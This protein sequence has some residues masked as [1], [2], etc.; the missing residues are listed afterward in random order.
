MISL[1]YI[2]I[3]FV[4]YRIARIVYNL[5]LHPLAKVPGP[6]LYAA[7]WFPRLWR[8]HHKGRHHTDLVQLHEKY[9]PIVRV[10]PD[11]VSNS[12]AAAW[13]AIGGGSQQFMRDPH[14]FIVSQLQT[15]GSKSFISLE[16]SEH[17][18]I[19]KL[20]MPAFSNKT[21]LLHE[22]LVNSWLGKLT[23]H[24][25]AKNGAELNI[26]RMF[27]W[28]TFDVMGALSFGENFG[29][30]DQEKDHQYLR[31][32]ELG[33]PC[34]SIMQILLRFPATQGL[35]DVAR[36]LP[37][38]RLWNSLREMSDDSASRWLETVHDEKR[39]D[40]MATV[41]RGMQN[42][43]DPISRHE[44]LDVASILV[45]SGAEATPILMTAM[46]WN[47]LSNPRC[48]ER[49]CRDVRES[50]IINGP[51]DF[52]AA[53]VEKIPYMEAVMLEALRLDTPFA[54]T[55]PRIVP[56]GGAW[57]DGYWLPGG[58]SCGIPHYTAGHWAQNF[59]DPDTFVPERWM[60]S[61]RPAK[62]ES[63]KRGVFRPFS[64]GS[65]DCIGQRFVR[66]EVG[67]A[68]VALLWNFDFELSDRSLDW[69]T[70]NGAEH[71]RI[72]RKKRPL[73][74]KAIPRNVPSAV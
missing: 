3:G 10:G 65:L 9:G 1:V 63:D 42:T 8:Q 24:I 54:T 56:E 62:Y 36:K 5:Y 6:K 28:F 13:D 30:L 35:Y 39:T 41:Y 46:L 47:L 67:M 64:K 11:E 19:R 57:V 52:T 4:L 31:A 26:E 72:I 61:E 44:A 17:H 15:T 73:W 53:N 70:A 48:Y 27:V 12:S 21:Y 14:F 66:H 58:T 25:A 40:I 51:A 45:L 18:S 50:G 33:A 37:W 55:I 2:T 29:C 74:V 68:F 34:L 16:K 49:L 22:S 59:S 71:I 23:S 43:K 20:M 38:M 69:K 7:S 60:A 32:A